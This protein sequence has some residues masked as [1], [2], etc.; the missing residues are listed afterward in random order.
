MTNL[1]DLTNTLSRKLTSK[2]DK[3]ETNNQSSFVKYVWKCIASLYVYIMIN[4]LIS[5]NNN[6]SMLLRNLYYINTNN[7]DTKSNY[8]K[9]FKFNYFSKSNFDLDLQI[10]INYLVSGTRG[11]YT[12]FTIFA[13]NLYS[14]ALKGKNPNNHLTFLKHPIGHVSIIRHL[15]KTFNISSDGIS[16]RELL[17][18]IDNNPELVIPEVLYIIDTLRIEHDIEVDSLYSLK[19]RQGMNENIAALLT[20]KI[21]PKNFFKTINKNDVNYVNVKNIPGHNLSSNNLGENNKTFYNIDLNNDTSYVNVTN[22]PGHNLSSNNLGENNNNNIDLNNNINPMRA[23]IIGENRNGNPIFRGGKKS[24]AKKPAK[25]PA[26]QSTKKPAKKPVKKPTSKK[27]NRKIY[28]GPR[29]GK[30]YISN[31]KKVYL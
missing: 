29:G 23:T 8:R 10:P 28:K 16:V 11:D 5:R 2:I 7:K 26:K 9:N 1:S 31:N 3:S 21:E 19:L 15:K 4:L 6:E 18:K 30:Y 17:L 20:G 24:S 27:T 22:I 12:R 25:K 13:I 14:K